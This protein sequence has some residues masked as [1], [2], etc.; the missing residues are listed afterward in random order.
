MI[1]VIG[2]QRPSPL[3]SKKQLPGVRRTFA[4][5]LICCRDTIP[6][7]N[8]DIRQSQGNVFIKVERC[9]LRGAVRGEARVNHLFMLPVV[10]ECRI[11]GLS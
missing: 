11:H 10:C 7:T 2:E 3:S 1:A 6:T 9:H 5:L 8:K 4:P